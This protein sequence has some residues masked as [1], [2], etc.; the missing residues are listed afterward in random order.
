M[1][2]VKV[3]RKPRAKKHIPDPRDGF[4]YDNLGRIMYHPDYHP[5]HGSKFE[6]EELCYIAKFYKFDGRRAISFALGRPE[7]PVQKKYLELVKHGKIA[8]YQQMD[9]YC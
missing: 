9:Y 2:I 5:N 6:E 8:Q 4:T 3:S 7:G 1:G